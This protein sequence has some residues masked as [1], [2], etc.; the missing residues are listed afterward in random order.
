VQPTVV[1]TSIE[2][3]GREVQ[4]YCTAIDVGLRLISGYVTMTPD[5]L[6]VVQQAQLNFQAYCANPPANV[7]EALAFLADTY[8]RILAAQE[9][10]SAKRRVAAARRA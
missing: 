3:A 4:R 2:K 6:N 5:R 7:P 10:A 9:T 1:D 8:T